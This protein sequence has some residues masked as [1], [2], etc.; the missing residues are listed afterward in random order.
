MLYLWELGTSSS[1][2]EDRFCS[3]AADVKEKKCL[4]F[5]ILMAEPVVQESPVFIPLLGSSRH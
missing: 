2:S 3:R 1:T 4:K 5:K